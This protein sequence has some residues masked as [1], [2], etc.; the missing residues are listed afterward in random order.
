MMN[1]NLLL[2]T[3]K[4]EEIPKVKYEP[5]KSENKACKIVTIIY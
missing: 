5:V 4:E 2:H 3:F 1:E